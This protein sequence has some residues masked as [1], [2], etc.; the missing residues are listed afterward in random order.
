M[1]LAFEHLKSFVLGVWFVL[2]R[3]HIFVPPIFCISETGIKF[4]SVSKIDFI[5][6]IK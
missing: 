5:V 3:K 1:C 4:E 6:S 2:I